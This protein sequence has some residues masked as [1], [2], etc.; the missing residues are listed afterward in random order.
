MKIFTFVMDML[1]AFPWLSFTLLRR[2]E[3]RR[4]VASIS[5]D[6]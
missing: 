1:V 4:F 3:W 5:H 2:L 6:S